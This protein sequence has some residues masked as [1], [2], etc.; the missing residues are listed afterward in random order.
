MRLNNIARALLCILIILS[1]YSFGQPSVAFSYNK[2]VPALKL[3]GYDLV[4][5]DPASNFNPIE[6]CTSISKPLAYVSLGEVALDAPYAKDISSNWVIGKN[7]A[8][9]NNMIMDQTQ[10]GW[11]DYFLN[12]MIDPLW[13]KGYRGFFLDTLDSFFLTTKDPQLQQ[14][15][16]DGMA[17][18][19]QQI[20]IRH[21][22]ATV[23]LNRG[24]Q[25][26]P[27]VHNQV[28][29]VVIESLYNAWNQAKHIY[30]NTS[31]ADQKM[32]WDQ[33]NKI[34]Q[35]Q[36]PIIIIDY[37]PP[38][39]QNKAQGLADALAKQGFIPWITDSTLQEL[40]LNK[41][42]EIPR[43]VLIIIRYKTFLPFLY[44]A[45]FG[46]VNI[47]L[48]YLGYRTQY[49]NLDENN[50]LPEGNLSQQYAGIIVFI[51][52]ADLKNIPMFQW[53]Q[54]QISAKIPIVF[55]N[56]FAIPIDNKELGNLN[57]SY[58]PVEIP[59][60]LLQI[61]K[62]DPNYI[63][64]DM[65]PTTSP[66]DFYPIQSKL[67]KVLLQFKSNKQ[68]TEDAVAITPWGGYALLPNYIQYLPN[69]KALWVINPF[70]FFRQAL[71]L[72]DFPVPDTTTENGRRL[73][74]VHID[75]DGFSLLAKWVGGSYAGKELR[76]K[77]LDRFHIPTSVSVITGEI[78]P[79]GIHPKISGTL[80][81]I[82][83]SIFALPWVES[84][85]HSFSHPFN[86]QNKADKSGMIQGESYTLTIPDYKFNLETEITGSVD[87]INK[88]LTPENR[89]C[90]LI[91]WS[92]MA[93]PDVQALSIAAKDNLLN[94]NGMPDTN[95]NLRYPSITSIQPM[96]IEL[97]GYYQVFS[98]IDG[99]FYYINGL[100]GPMYGY[101]KVI[102][103]LELTDKPRRFKPIDLYYHIYSA[104]YP[105]T[106]EALIKVYQ[107]ALS[108]PV[109][110]IYISDY[111]KKVI[112]SFQIKIVP[113]G[114]S[115]IIYSGGDLRELRSQINKGYPDLTKSQNIIGFRT[116]NNE[117]YLHL[118]PNRF[119]VVTYQK[120]KP[121]QPYLV[122]ANGTVSAFSRTA[123]Q[124]II[125]FKSYMPLQFTLDNV[126]LCK[127]TSQ[128]PLIITVNK[129]NTISYS[130]AK[131][132]DEIHINC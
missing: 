103:T 101:E 1:N 3:C 128:N 10:K 95:I 40:Y 64:Y 82:A 53:V 109:M 67:G 85:S 86:W 47:I 4:V 37:L 63:G 99:D 124:L 78:A 11:Q 132:N 13:N 113:K 79:N 44:I 96:G 6:Y 30:E 46:R 26:L 127:V 34:R 88:Y 32:L 33:I 65:K 66:Y 72:K 12:Q 84:A 16:I 131:D 125:N 5:V 58:T 14:K 39:Q 76:D 59:D 120:D 25:L 60:Q 108:Q 17:N 2:H 42:R 23:I 69:Y 8:W 107:W 48:E 7:V 38:A 91:F 52:T 27:Q 106:L 122:E 98:P 119:T 121:T 49:L 19:I 97:G 62:L 54:K 15:Q 21:P 100:A 77:I 22:E 18:L 31:A 118:G 102:Q 115:W 110:N 81:D 90:H 28:D 94:I 36:L 112:D 130:S 51:D 55:I 80:M 56:S 92:G 74:S 111:I 9:N 116:I 114:D 24:F 20:K 87:F 117:L 68:Q 129:D 57:I 123:K 29:E 93:D 73:M 75:G 50:Q 41:I 61:T 45:N 104:G 71:H 83:R 105:A 70:E 126:T 35:L 43:T 89:K